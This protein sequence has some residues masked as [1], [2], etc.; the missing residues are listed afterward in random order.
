MNK[1]IYGLVCDH[2][3]LDENKKH[4]YIGIFD[5]L[6]TYERV[7]YAHPSFFVCFKFEA[8]DGEHTLRATIGPEDADDTSREEIAQGKF[9]V[10]NKSGSGM[11]QIVG[12]EFAKPGKWSIY[13]SIDGGGDMKVADFNVNTVSKKD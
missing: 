7:N 3:F 4:V 12:K 10:I 2:A 13:L 9:S 5:R 6:T 1:I 8:T 11:L